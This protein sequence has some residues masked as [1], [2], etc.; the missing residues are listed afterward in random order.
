MFTLS[1]FQ[2]EIER[3]L[4]HNRDK[5]LFYELT[6][7]TLVLTPAAETIEL[8]RVKA[9]EI[10]LF[11]QAA[12][13]NGQLMQVMESAASQTIQLFWE[14]NQYLQFSRRH[15]AGLQEIYGHLFARLS[16]LGEQT[17]IGDEEIE[18]IFAA[19]YKRLQAFLIY[20]NGSQIF[21]TYR[22]HP[23]LPNIT[24]AEYTPEFQLAVLN[25][26]L[27]AI[28]SPVLDIGCGAQAS[29]IR[30]I[31]AHGIPTVGIDRNVTPAGDLHRSGWFE[32][33]FEP[34]TWGTVIS[35]MAFSNHFTHH[36][37]K[38]DGEHERYA[39]AYMD[40]L[41]S[42]T[43]GGRF[44]YAP[45]LPFMEEVLP[46]SPGLPFRTETYTYS[47]HIVRTA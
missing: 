44:V 23:D 26:D 4:V 21:R 5:S 27:S 38:A 35:H 29:L 34:N 42:L 32:Y 45:R 43:V 39:R 11:M 2:R 19:H 40:I 33:T 12:K 20:S 47:T 3:Q 16:R 14:V 10:S 8:L 13:T 18:P 41:R 1:D 25:L 31:Q 24:C 46:S 15:Y 22:D 36:H 30:Y 17:V 37:L 9:R 28:A 7:G 6:G